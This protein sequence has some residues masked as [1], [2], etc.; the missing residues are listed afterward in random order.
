LQDNETKIWQEVTGKG[1]CHEY[2]ALGYGMVW[3]GVQ[4]FYYT[5]KTA[6]TESS[7]QE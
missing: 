7:M 5:R 6:E 2:R 3:Y 4:H 1:A